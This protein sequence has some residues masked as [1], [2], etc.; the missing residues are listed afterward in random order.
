[1]TYSLGL[2][3]GGTKTECA[4]L[5]ANGQVAG[6]GVA[7]PSNPLRIGFDAAAGALTLAARAALTSAGVQTTQVVS[8]CAGLA[9]AG[10]PSVASRVSAFLAAEFPHAFVHATTD[11]EI[12][13]EAAVGAGPGVVLIAGTGSSAY[14]RNAAGKTA[15]AGGHGR[16][17]GDEGSAFDIGR[18]ALAA[19]ALARDEGEPP[20]RLAERIFA[21]LECSDW[22]DLTE[23]IAQSPD[24]VFPVIFPVVIEAAEAGDRVARDILLD[25][26]TA[27]ASLADIVIRQLGLADGEF[28]LAISGGALGRSALLD[29]PLERSL[30]HFAPRAR[31]GPLRV[32]PAIGAARL[33]KR[34]TAPQPG[35]GARSTSAYGSED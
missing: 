10:G 27:L 29:W 2:D 15:R 26:A 35:S 32:S 33:A 23:R 6:Q 17:L 21:A 14:G 5:D 8:V 9:G 13:L 16:W 34:L 19:V 12:A 7:G 31:I 3:G 22:D 18:R 11:L 24:E 4:V 30:L 25:A 1:M 20:M 28:V